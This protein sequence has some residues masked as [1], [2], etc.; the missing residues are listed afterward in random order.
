M[1]FE[2]LIGNEKVKELLT[3]SINSNTILHS[4]LFV[5]IEGIGKSLFAKEFA[6][7][8]LCLEENKYC[9]KCTSCLEIE[10]N[11]HPDF[12]QIEPDGNS[13]K[14]EQI[15]F[16]QQKIAEKPIISK[17][18]VYI[19][20]NAD[21]M[22]KEAQNSLL[23]TLEEPPEYAV[24]ILIASNESNLLNTI[25]SRCT[26]IA[27]QTIENEKIERY[28][29]ENVSENVTKSMIDMC[30]GSIGK[31]LKLKEGQEIYEEL[32][33]L[34]Q[35]LDTK[36]L[37]DIMNNTEL[38]SKSKDNIYEILD[39]LNIILYNTR[40]I[41]KIN[42]IKLVEEAKKRLQ[43]NS[44]FDMTIDNLLIKMWEEVNEK[45]NRS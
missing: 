1:G 22:T 31:A 19:I 3:K 21:S 32:E 35:N 18:K 28:I 2:N 39:Y 25:K 37:I 27:F 15:R 41:N 7:A 4:Y 11:N 8:I 24:I 16:L 12:M 20:N 42:C 10:N 26:K 23:K 6:K 38:F 29:K 40:S 13:V 33:K 44:N 30:G 9:M 45:Y 5:G 14:I 43:A 36:D 34:V 17:N